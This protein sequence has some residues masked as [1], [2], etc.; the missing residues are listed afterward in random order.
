MLVAGAPRVVAG[1][2]GVAAL[3]GIAAC[4]P[5]PAQ[6][7]VVEGDA[8]ALVSWSGASACCGSD[9][10]PV[11]GAALADGSVVMVGK[12]GASSRQTA[13][14]ITRWRAP[15][16][17]ATGQ[18]VD[19]MDEV[20]LASRRLGA[21]SAL[22]QVAEAGDYLVAVGFEAGSRS[23]NS[24]GI[25]L[26]LD[27]AT[28]EEVARLRV[29][30]AASD[31]SAALEAVIVDDEGTIALGGSWNFSR[32]QLE[33]FKSYGNIVGGRGVV[34]ELSLDAWLAASSGE[35]VTPAEVSAVVREIPQVQSLKSLARWPDTSVIAVGHDRDEVSGMVWVEPGLVDHR[36]RAYDDRIELTDVAVFERP[37][38]GDG[39]ALIG[40][41]GLHTIDGHVKLVDPR[42]EVL[43]STAFGNPGVHPSEQP[44]RGLAPKLLIFDECWGAAQ[45]GDELVVACGTGIEAC[46]AV[47]V[48]LAEWRRCRRDPRRS[49]RSYLAGLDAEGAVRWS[50]ADS[51]VEHSGE[52]SESA[53]EFVTVDASGTVY[54]VVD[55]DF[56]VGLARFD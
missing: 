37:D 28:L 25:A 48:T 42:G 33:G 8:P 19:G 11:H 44:R 38:R 40:H 29:G 41:G 5:P 52:A 1:W 30:A 21:D 26:L 12:A 14:F 50:R 36:W 9:P 47:P 23:G 32:G 17:P 18:F 43:W 10:H 51:F 6:V 31:R 20:I 56:G 27:P 35:A 7:S 39:I 16:E 49:W 13:G 4:G 46:G 53:A 45:R 55:H 54:A 34:I 15:D 24:N 3:V 22:L 2:G